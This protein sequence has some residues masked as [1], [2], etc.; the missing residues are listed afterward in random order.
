[1]RYSKLPRVSTRQFTNLRLFVHFLRV[2]HGARP[3][4]HS[5]SG[6]RSYGAFPRCG[7]NHF[8]PRRGPGGLEVVSALPSGQAPGAGRPGCVDVLD[9][10]QVRVLGILSVGRDL[11][12]CAAD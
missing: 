2:C 3:V 11:E 6:R 4:C 7:G 5:V 10:A 12:P 1:V 8:E 9:G